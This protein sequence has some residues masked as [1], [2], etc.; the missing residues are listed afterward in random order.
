MKLEIQS[1]RKEN[2]KITA[3]YKN[4]KTDGCFIVQGFLGRRAG[5]TIFKA[6]QAINNLTG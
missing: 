6:Q 1:F 2:G 5:M 4:N 3:I